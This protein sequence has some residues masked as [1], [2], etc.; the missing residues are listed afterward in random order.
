MA[1]K[2]KKLSFTKILLISAVIVLAVGLYNSWNRYFSYGLSCDWTGEFSVTDFELHSLQLRDDFYVATDS[3]SQLVMTV[4]NV[5]GGMDFV[6]DSS[7]PT[8]EVL[9]YYTTAPGQDYTES[10]RTWAVPSEDG[11]KLYSFTIPA[12]YV[13]TLRIDPTIYGGNRLYFGE[14]ILNPPRQFSDFVNF[15]AT[16]LPVVMVCTGLLASFFRF[17][18]EIFT[19]KS[20]KVYKN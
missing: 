13:H 15:S 11:E 19:K 9:V 2:L 18:Q 3:D 20:D 12:Q 5:I 17:V 14:F 6:M 7:M 1:D 8:G 4:D 16:E 10:Q